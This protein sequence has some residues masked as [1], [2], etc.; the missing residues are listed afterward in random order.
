VP[1]VEQCKSGDDKHPSGK[2]QT[3]HTIC[4]IYQVALFLRAV[5]LRSQANVRSVG[6][7]M[8]RSQTRFRWI[9]DR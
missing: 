1:G 3:P 9:G 5:P 6:S 7:Q 4:A 8:R 2:T